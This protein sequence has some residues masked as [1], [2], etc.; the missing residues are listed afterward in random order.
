MIERFGERY[1][2]YRQR[3]PMFFPRH[4][5]WGRLLER[6]EPAAGADE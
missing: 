2:V 6:P 4:G 3:L 1:L 5:D